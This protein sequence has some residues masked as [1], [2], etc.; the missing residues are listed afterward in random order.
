MKLVVLAL[1][2][3]SGGTSGGAVWVAAWA[4]AG[5]EQRP[6][7]DGGGACKAAARSGRAGIEK[8]PPAALAGELQGGSKTV[9]VFKY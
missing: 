4:G 5:R 8:R 2:A 7:S 1:A 3:G 9:L 6:N